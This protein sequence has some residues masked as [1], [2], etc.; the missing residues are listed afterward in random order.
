LR[1]QKSQTAIR[2][3]NV[4]SEETLA[5]ALPGVHSGKRK[6]PAATPKDLARDATTASAVLR[7]L[8]MM[9]GSAELAVDASLFWTILS[10]STTQARCLNLSGPKTLA[11]ELPPPLS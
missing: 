7:L 5:G 2:W 8:M 9:A 6:P 4:K 11:S 3:I 10:N 1:Y